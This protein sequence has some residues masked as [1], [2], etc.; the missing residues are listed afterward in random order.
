MSIN[1]WMAKEAVVRICEMILLSHKRNTFKSGLLR[2][3]NLQP[4]I[5]SEVSQKEKQILCFNAYLWNLE[6]WYK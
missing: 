3:M 5:Q 4:V 6:K 1:R 2:W